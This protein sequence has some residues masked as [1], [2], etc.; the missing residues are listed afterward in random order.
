MSR[1]SSTL[2]LPSRELDTCLKHRLAFKPLINWRITLKHLTLTAFTIASV[3]AAA[4][5]IAASSPVSDKI[6]SEQR[7]KLAASTNGKGFGPQAPRDI[8][9]ISGS[10]PISFSQA[11]DFSQMN[12]CNIHMHDGAEHKGGDFTTY[13]GNGDGQGFGTGF[14][15][16]GELSDSELEPFSGTVGASEHGELQPG[17]TIEVHYVYTTAEITPGPTLEAC[18]SEATQNPQLRVE[19]QVMVLV[20]DGDANSFEDLAEVQEVDGFY[21][22][23]NLPEDTGEAVHYIGS[24]T[25]PAYNVKGSPLQVTWSVRPEVSKVDI[26]SLGAWFEENPFDE[27]SAHGSRN[28]V[29]NPDLLSDS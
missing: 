29:T 15:Y 13:R 20:N 19:T 8:D 12:L 6:I 22:A 21:Q 17:D 24:T 28:L 10:N 7:E 26:E 27:A 9:D 1:K 18:L 23:I 11:P 25:G 2:L 5:V 4:G 14:S 3:T 16:D